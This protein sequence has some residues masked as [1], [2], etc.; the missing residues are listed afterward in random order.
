MIH[1]GSFILGTIGGMYIAQNYDVP[2]VKNLS[3]KIIDYL[4]SIEKKK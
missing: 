3:T 1:L 2:D 4:N